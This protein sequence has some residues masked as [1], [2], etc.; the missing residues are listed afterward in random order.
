MDDGGDVA[1]NVAG[2]VATVMDWRSSPDAKRAAVAYLDS[3]KNGDVRLLG[4]TS[5][6]LVRKDWSSEIR[7]HGLKMLQHL[8][9]LRW[10]EL[11]SPERRDFANAAVDLLSEMANPLEEWALKS[12]TAALVAEIVRREGLDLWQELLPSFVSL[13]NKGPIEA[14]LVVML[15]RW[16]PED[17]TVHNEDLEGDRRRLLLRGLAQSLPQIL[18]LLYSLLERHFMGA[19]NEASRQQFDTAKQHAATVTA[20]LNAVNAYAEWAPVSDLAKFKLIYG[21][22]FLLSSV[23]FRLHACEFFRLVC[24]RKRPMDE[25][26]HDFDSA[27]GSIFQI[28]M[29]ISIDFLCKSSTSVSEINDS[30]VEFA[31]CV[32]ES[33]VA[34]GSS[35]MQCI[36]RDD[37]LLP[38]YIQEM[39]GYFQHVKFGLHFRSLQFWQVLM[40]DL[41]SKTKVIMQAAEGS[42][43]DKEKRAVRLLINDEIC[44]AILDVSFQRMTKKSVHSGVVLSTE[45]LELWNEEFDA[46]VDFSQYRSKLLELIRLVTIHNPVVAAAKVSHGVQ[47]IINGYAIPPVAP[48]GLLFLE[49]M[50]LG[51][52][53][54]VGAIFDA[55]T[56]V[57]STSTDV[58][59][60][61]QRILEGLLQRLLGTKWTEPAP[62]EILARYLDAFG[63]FL[64]SF[65]EAVG[66]VINKL[67][68][69]LTSLPLSLEGSS[70]ISARHARL[71]ICTSFLRIARASDKS[72]LPHMKGIADTMAHLQGEARLHRGEHN[73]LGEAFLVMASSA[74]IQQQKEVLAWLLESVNKEWT[75]L[76][77]QNAYLSDPLGLIR[78]CSD[79]PIMWSIFH[80]VTFFE[81][82][83][84]RSGAKKGNLNLQNPLSATEVSTLAHPMSSHLPWMLPSLLR[85][86]CS[87]HSLWAQPI[88]RSL[89]A[90][91]R[92]AMTISHVEQTS[93]LGEGVSKLSKGQ[94]SLLEGSSMET[95]KEGCTGSNEND[96]RNW[97]KGIRDS[98]YNVLGLSTMIGE[99][100]FQCLKSSDVA[101][102]LLGN[103]Q[104]MDFRHIRQLIHLV[105]IPLVKSC[106]PNLWEEWLEKLLC[107]LFVHCQQ[108]LKFSWSSLLSEGRTKV[109]DIFGN[110]SGLELKVEVM[111]EKLLRDLTRE[112][113]LLL[114]VLASPARNNG[115]PSF[116]QLANISRTDLLSLKDLNAFA[117]NSMVGFL[118]SHKN[119]AL[120][121]LQISKE[122]FTWTDGDSVS[123]VASFCGVVILLAISTNNVELREFVAKDLFYALIQGFAFTPLY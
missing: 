49:N 37:N 38:Q 20:A 85:L 94:L 8:V 98:G 62:A 45:P 87:I 32:C 122:A 66:P 26:A 111:E 46:K 24:Q 55:S 104:S 3:I 91:L 31:E 90:E 4:S 112:I 70:A 102:A 63:P 9:R 58:K 27:M 97:L 65:P 14:E 21:C 76:E 17:I 123:K 73:I 41:V 116:E 84:R 30:E 117:S 34:L 93:L 105:L 33:M 61:V 78:L 92:A 23:D 99:S 88:F 28:L 36:I 118:L 69:L 80:N 42:P 13:S 16:L 67:F 1:A 5:F 53:T 47:S 54:I 101:L 19:F 86:I 108:A 56:S 103:V 109:P 82:A 100:F 81:K 10:G 74:G 43:V 15:L 11:S 59:F 52:E 68:E 7:L 51:L 96:I 89:P 22:G 50:Q 44:A 110:P 25:S 40:K 119:L 77:W 6:F 71:Q 39:L 113:C 72:I 121:V 2:A 115:I 79:A 18:P 60:G 64:R 12:Q 29:N 120:P 35:F 75:Q 83:L 57:L 95:N 107:P 48:Q 106:P 114:S